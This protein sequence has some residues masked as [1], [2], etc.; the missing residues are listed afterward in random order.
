MKEK[1]ESLLRHITYDK[2][3]RLELIR[4]ATCRNVVVKADISTD[5]VISYYELWNEFEEK[6]ILMAIAPCARELS[7]KQVELLNP[8]FDEYK[9]LQ[10]DDEEKWYLMDWLTAQTEYQIPPSLRGIREEALS[11]SELL[12]WEYEEIKEK[13][14]YE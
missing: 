5:G 6:L 10:P 11:L 13:Y 12:D 1:I 2:F 8:G 14:L 4:S 3:E 9:V 7:E